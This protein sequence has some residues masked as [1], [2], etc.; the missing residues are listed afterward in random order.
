MSTETVVVGSIIAGIRFRTFKSFPQVATIGVFRSGATLTFGQLI[1]PL[2]YL[3]IAYAAIIPDEISGGWVE[4]LD[5]MGVGA[6]GGLQRLSDSLVESWLEKYTTTDVPN[7][8]A[9]PPVPAVY[10]SLGNIIS[11]YQPPFVPETHSVDRV[12]VDENGNSYILQHYMF[13]TGTYD[14]N[15][16]KIYENKLI[17]RKV[18][19]LGAIV[20]TYDIQDTLNVRCLAVSTTG[21]YVYFAQG[22]GLKII[23]LN[24]ATGVDATG[25][26]FPIT[27][28][29]PE[30]SDFRHLLYGRD[31]YLY[32]TSTGQVTEFEGLITKINPLDGSTVWQYHV[33]PERYMPINSIH[34]NKHG[35]L[36][37]ASGGMGVFDPTG[38]AVT[39]LNADGTKKYSVT[40]GATVDE[41]P[42]S[43]PICYGAVITDDGTVYEIPNERGI[44]KIEYDPENPSRI[45]FTE[46]NNVKTDD[47]FNLELRHIHLSPLQDFLFVEGD[48][49]RHIV[50]KVD[51]LGNVI[52][53]YE[54]HDGGERVADCISVSNIAIQPKEILGRR[55]DIYIKSIDGGEVGIGDITGIVRKYNS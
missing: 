25:N 43:G 34:V 45:G 49:H 14:E 4:P 5:N 11:P 35:E 16:A 29:Q 47:G 22:F 37:A 31:G 2:C 17:I 24:G 3:Y 55:I 53:K 18:D 28:S 26:G 30:Y 8:S 40:S 48:L 21:D 10:D 39:V 36:V 46:F 19:I 27:V 1:N 13:D 12:A 9:R 23:R 41:I 32:I 20:W 15:N 44:V 52:W 7:S 33:S 38:L 51:L 50:F 6:Y 42:V 54:G